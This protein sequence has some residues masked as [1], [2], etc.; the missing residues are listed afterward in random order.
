MFRRL[1]YWSITVGIGIA[2]ALPTFAFDEKAPH[3]IINP[4]GVANP[5]GIVGVVV[6]FDMLQAASTKFQRANG[7]RLVNLMAEESARA[8]ERANQLAEAKR[9]L[10][11]PHAGSSVTFSKV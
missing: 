2:L 10:L 9:Q 5:P 6:G 4:A 11:I 7:L 8:T 1:R 3:N